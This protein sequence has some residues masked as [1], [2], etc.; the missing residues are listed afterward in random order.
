MFY[1]Y[2][3][4]CSSLGKII[5]K[6]GKL[7]DQN[8]TYLND[9]FIGEIY[10]IQKE[11][12]SKYFEK[13]IICEQ[14]GRDFL[15]EIFYPDRYVAKNRMRFS[16][17][18]IHG[19]PDVIM[20]DYIY[21]IKNAYDLFTFGKAH[22]SWEYEWQLKGYLYLLNREKGR[23]F[24]ILADMPDTLLADEERKLFYQAKFTSTDSELYQKALEEVRKKYS[25]SH[26]PLE[27][28][29]KVFNVELLETDI[30]TINNSVKEARSYLSKLAKNYHEMITEN[31]KY[32]N[33]SRI[34][35]TSS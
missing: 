27:C 7:T 19:E 11:I 23:L 20:E 30:E 12:T 25:Y 5:S 28:R 1:N 14:D 3:F 10:K 35:T 22:L 2:K 33:E 34:N 15:K 32:L 8:K 16:N 24:Y 26:I 13:G 6:S 17:D 29:F 21:D 9:L 31:K 18:F 4:R